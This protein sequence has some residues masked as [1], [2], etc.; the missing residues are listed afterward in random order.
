MEHNILLFWGEKVWNCILKGRAKWGSAPSN[1]SL[2]ETK[3]RGTELK[4][5]L[6]SIARPLLRHIHDNPAYAYGQIVS[7]SDSLPMRGPIH[8]MW[9]CWDNRM[10]GCVYTITKCLKFVHPFTWHKLEAALGL[11]ANTVSDEQDSQCLKQCVARGM[12]TLLAERV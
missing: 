4:A 5:S 11:W 10:G 8:W 2:Q 1:P 12:S 3:A 6:C 7:V 9:D